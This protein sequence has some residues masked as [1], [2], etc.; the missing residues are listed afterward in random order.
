MIILT[1]KARELLNRVKPK[2]S[3]PVG[4]WNVRSGSGKKI[5]ET[6]VCYAPRKQGTAWVVKHRRVFVA[7]FTGPDAKSKAEA[8]ACKLRQHSAQLRTAN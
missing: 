7:D 1:D 2:A 4:T 8:L 3:T 5:P 6:M